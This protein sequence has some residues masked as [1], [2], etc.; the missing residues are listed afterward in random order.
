ME[1]P[2][3]LNQRT[4][5]EAWDELKA[6]ADAGM[7][8]QA[9]AYRLAFADPEFLLRRETRG[10]RIQL[11]LMKPD[12]EQQIQGIAHTLVVFGSARFLAP[13]AAQAQLEQA[14]AGGDMEA[15][16][17]AEQRAV[18]RPG[19]PVRPT[20]R[21]AQCPVATPGTALHLHGWR[22]GHHGGGEPRRA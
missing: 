4:L 20:G 16:A 2:R 10:I 6:H 13:E 15:I 18:L 19:P 7:T 22:S 14:R 5:A 17:R 9:D 3:H 1:A 11:E 12:L 21:R 8:L